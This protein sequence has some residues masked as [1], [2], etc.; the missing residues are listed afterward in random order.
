MK[1]FS[2]LATCMLLLSV[3]SLKA[4]KVN[5]SGSVTEKESGNPL[6][7]VNV[8]LKGTTVGTVT[9]TDGSFSLKG[10]KPGDYE[11][12]VSC[13][14]YKRAIDTLSL[15]NDISGKQYSLAPSTSNMGEVVVTGT[16]TP[17][18]LKNAPVQTE[19]IS[20]KLIT[21]VAPSNFTDLMSTISPSFDFTPGSMGAFMQLNG[22]SNDY[23]V[24]LIDG[25]RV[26]GDIGGNNDLN[27]INPENVERIE[28]VKGASSALYGSDAI[29]G[30]INVIT[31]KSNKKFNLTDNTR[32]GGYGEFIQHN[33][34]NLKFNRFTSS[35]SLDYKHT[36][37][38]QLSKYTEDDGEL[39]ETDARAQ[40]E[41]TDYTLSQ[42]FTYAPTQNLN[43]YVQG[44]V[45]E[46]DIEKPLSVSEYGY[47]YDNLSYSA[48]AKY[49]LKKNAY[50]QA[51]WN[52]D[53]FNYYY[54]YNQDV[55][56]DGYLTGDKDKQTEQIRDNLNIRSG[57]GVGD[58]QYFTLGG[59]YINEELKTDR[60]EDETVAAYTNALYVQDELKPVKNLTVV[61]GLRYVNHK[62]FGNG[63]TPK[64]AL[65][66]K[67]K[68]FNLRGTYARGYKAPTLKELYY[69]YEK[70]MR[71]KTYLF[72]GNHD[73]KPQ[74]SN[75]YSASVEYYNSRIMSSITV[76]Q[77]N[78]N[79]L[80]DT[81]SI[82]LTEEEEA[83]G[84][85]TKKQYSNI[86]EAR[87]KGVDFIF[88]VS[89]GA[90][91]SVGGGY[92]YVDAQNLTDTVRLENVAQNYANIRAGY[93]HHWKK[94]SLSANLS[95]RIQDGKYYD[96]GNSKGYNLWKLTT[97]HKFITSGAFD[98]G[99][100]AGIDNIFDYVDDSPY[101]SNYGTINPGRTYFAGINFDFSL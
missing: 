81:K 68:N 32:V 54:K 94:Y 31:K 85:T 6:I 93:H 10:I 42:K 69:Y 63:F 78:V 11:V 83:N 87:T 91:F 60:S 14:G 29:A 90:G 1:K 35:T 45:Y 97:T 101:G 66:Y 41:S 36:D 95:G 99:A 13:L 7:G 19:L 56:D 67:I 38:W 71:G 46:R 22:L 64:I 43:I 15:T 89:L 55:E 100:T 33:S 77:N 98:L 61:A 44:A 50:V 86:A 62:E 73:L 40:D 16:A 4:Q 20:K 96:D 72:V 24:V 5:L 76:Y 79:D 49:L 59:E 26:S 47:L 28:V 74:T 70:T 25:K 82:D 80:I 37:G 34:L 52:S 8:Y 48:G 27:R 58:W 2:L 65:L 92:S 21:E 12:I 9:T 75:Y 3:Y 17:H 53:D 84:I 23:I 30:V 51:D 18:H 57:F 88:N 39:V